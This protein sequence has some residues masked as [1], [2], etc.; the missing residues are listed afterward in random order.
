[1]PQPNR[2]LAFAT[3]WFVIATRLLGTTAAEEPT[4]AWTFSSAQLQPF[5]HSKT[6]LG[7]SV[8]LAESLFTDR[9]CSRSP[10]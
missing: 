4:V 10:R 7:E 9:N 3:A 5:W 8:L 2:K 1:M 6:M